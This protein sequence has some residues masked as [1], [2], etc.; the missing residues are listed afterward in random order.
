M[1]EAW[2]LPNRDLFK[3]LWSFLSLAFPGILMLT[4][5][6]LNMEILVLLAGLL[7]DDDLLAACVML[8]AFGQFIIMIPYG[9]ALANVAMIGHALGAN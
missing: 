9:L 2:F 6:N 3:N 1:R 7:K 4:I 8:V 5:E